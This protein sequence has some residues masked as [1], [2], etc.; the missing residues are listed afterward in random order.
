MREGHIGSKKLSNALRITPAY[1]G[2][3]LLQTI[4]LWHSGDHPRLC[5]KDVDYESALLDQLG[6][7]PLMREGL[8]YSFYF[9][10]LDGITP[11]YAGRTLFLTGLRPSEWDH[12]RLCGKDDN[13]AQIPN[14]MSGSP[15]LMRE[16][17]QMIVTALEEAG[18]TPAYAGRT[19]L[20][21]Q[22]LY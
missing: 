3:T 13:I 6:S 5:G 11:A 12:P 7:P 2:R 20:F 21:E 16:G 22:F 8:R 19:T 17:Q 9:C 18:I 15:P 1:A 10:L 4:S 14:S